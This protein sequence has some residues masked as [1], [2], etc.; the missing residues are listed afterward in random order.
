[1]LVLSRKMDESVIIDG[2]IRITV[3]S[4]R[5]NQIRIGIEAPD[6]VRVYREEILERNQRGVPAA[7]I[8]Q[9]VSL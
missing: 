7:G 8:T 2:G 6:Q 1:M 9:A 3:L 5:G 4:I